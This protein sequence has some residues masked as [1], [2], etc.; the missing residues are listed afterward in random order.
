[1]WSNE[2]IDYLS[3]FFSREDFQ[4]FLLHSKKF[5]TIEELLNNFV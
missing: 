5:K 2:L 1:M 3:G 4:E